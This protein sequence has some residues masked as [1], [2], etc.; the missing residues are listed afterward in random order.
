MLAYKWCICA[1][2]ALLST[3][4]PIIVI[5]ATGARSLIQDDNKIVSQT[6]VVDPSGRGDFRTI[7]A[8]I[9]SIPS[10]NQR[11]ICV[12]IK[13]GRYKEKVTIA[14]DKPYIYLQGKGIDNTVIQWN[15][16]GSID[17]S[18]TFTSQ[19]DYTIAMG[20]KFVNSFNSPPN[21]NRNPLERA[22]A[23]LIAGDK[24]AF[25][26]CGFFG[27]QDTLWDVKGR[28]Y[29]KS[30]TI[31]GAVDFIFGAGQSLYESCMISVAA[32]ILKGT[33]GYITAQGRENP[34]DTSGFVFKDCKIAGNGKAYL[35]RA[36]R[37]Y[38]RVVFYNTLMSDIVVPQGWYAW[39]GAGKE[40][41]LT[42]S[43]YNCRGLG[44]ESSERV[45]WEKKLSE[46]EMKQLTSISFIDEEGWMN[47]ASRILG[48]S[49][50]P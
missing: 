11:W 2:V 8:A 19:A 48:R 27:I 38:A 35:G 21:G 33:P 23:A 40:D 14:R 4:S 28:H 36:W 31:E 49:K 50:L 13:E 32:G 15:D 1:F 22:V 10:Q 41:Q 20:I 17:T 34:H 37:E 30:C 45:E 18:A 42:M 16:H 47:Q 3:F 46:G 9:D 5:T 12:D 26:Q 6:I 25:Y 39:N 44:S 29:F 43:E 7:Q 24:S